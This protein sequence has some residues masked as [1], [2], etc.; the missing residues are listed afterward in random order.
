MK[1]VAIGPAGM[2]VSRIGLG[3]VTFGREIDEAAAHGLL[4]YAHPH[5]VSNEWVSR[6]RSAASPPVGL[7]G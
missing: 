2:R 5:G 3:C 1:A 4:D 6:D 7:D